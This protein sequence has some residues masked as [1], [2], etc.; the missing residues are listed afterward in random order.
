MI[1][2]VLGMSSIGKLTID[3]AHNQSH[4]DWSILGLTIPYMSWCFA[5]Y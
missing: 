3:A 2:S 4:H 1:D 5:Y